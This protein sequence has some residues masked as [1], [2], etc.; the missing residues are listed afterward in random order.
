MSFLFFFICCFCCWKYYYFFSLKKIIYLLLLITIIII[1]IICCAI[2]IIYLFFVFFS[3]ISSLLC[4]CPLRRLNRIYI[5][6]NPCIRLLTPSFP[7]VETFPSWKNHRW[8]KKKKWKKMN[9]TLDRYNEP[10]FKHSNIY[11]S[12]KYQSTTN[13]TGHYKEYRLKN[14]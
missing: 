6:N 3:H 5:G 7:L 14:T 13:K 4:C 10:D 12:R 1:I 11:T 2:I 9:Q 8:K